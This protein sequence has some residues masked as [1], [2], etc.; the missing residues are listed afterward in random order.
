LL[1]SDGVGWLVSS[2]H[3][4]TSWVVEARYD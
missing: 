3:P 2:E 4:S 1:D